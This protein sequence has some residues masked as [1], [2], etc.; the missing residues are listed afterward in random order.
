MKKINYLLLGFMVTTITNAQSISPSIINSA[1]GTAK[2][3][4]Y[5]IDWSFCEVT[6]AT[7]YATPKLIVTQGV[8]Q[9]DPAAIITT[10]VKTN[11]T[12]LNQSIIVYPNPSSN[13]IYLKSDQKTE[14]NFQYSLMDITGKLILDKSTDVSLC[15]KPET[16]DLSGLSVGVYIL[17]VTEVKNKETLTQTYKIQ[18]IN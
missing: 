18:K 1:G 2:A 8:L 17:K 10:S 7:T 9:N 12:V 6:L 11:P 16:V 15:D 3:G 14:T 13:L 4:G 5:I